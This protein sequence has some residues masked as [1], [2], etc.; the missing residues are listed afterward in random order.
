MSAPL[1]VGVPAHPHMP[2]RILIDSENIFRIQ[3]H[4]HMDITFT[5]HRV[6]R[7]ILQA[8]SIDLLGH[9]GSSREKFQFAFND[10][11]YAATVFFNFDEF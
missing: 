7:C 3:Q 2:A 1:V 11:K 5:M 4:F 8:K 9:V 10:G 6:I